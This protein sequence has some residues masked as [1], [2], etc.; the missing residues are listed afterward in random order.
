MLRHRV[1]V[2]SNLFPLPWQPNRGMF[3]R[4]HYNALAEFMDVLVLCPVAWTERPRR[5]VSA[6]PPVDYGLLEVHQKTYFFPPRIMRGSYGYFLWQSIKGTAIDLATRF[7][8]SLIAA[9]WAYPDGYAA[10]KLA[11]SLNLPYVIQTLGSDINLLGEFPERA[12]PTWNTLRQASAVTPVSQ[13]LRDK[14]TANGVPP[15]KVTVV[16]RGVD[17]SRF[18]PK[19]KR[20]AQ[21]VIGLEGSHPHLLFI[22]NLVPIKSVDTLIAASAELLNQERLEH[23]LH[24]VGD[25]PLRGNLQ[26]MAENL[27]LGDR[28]VFHGALPHER[29][30]DWFAATDL[31]VLPSLNEGVPNV[32]LE[33]M[34]CSRPYVASR[35]GGI[36]EISGHD[37]CTLFSAGDAQDLSR[38]IRAQL[39]KN[40][41][42]SV[43]DLLC[44]DWQDAGK[45]LADAFT[46][47]LSRTEA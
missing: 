35:V 12:T 8:P 16:Y 30:C 3:N 43:E 7:Q 40:N 24:I 9:S 22:G 20:A 32:L 44:S 36:P 39:I 34:A 10:M 6:F 11:R 2:I 31:V 26:Q 1:L 4:Q 27:G 42:P 25:G 17:T 41:H 45:K 23:T 19:Q 13:A 18:F 15:D 37:G 21:K 29:L 5:G 14:I 28:T 38:A 46:N 33:A 47:A